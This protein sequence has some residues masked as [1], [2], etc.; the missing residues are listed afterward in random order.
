MGINNQEMTT[1]LR[2]VSVLSSVENM[3]GTNLK[4]TYKKKKFN[5][6]YNGVYFTHSYEL[7][8]NKKY[9]STLYGDNIVYRKYIYNIIKSKLRVVCRLKRKKKP[10]VYVRF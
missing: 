5:N 7:F 8:L 1:H 2:I 6:T 9:V 4:V 3:L 10:R